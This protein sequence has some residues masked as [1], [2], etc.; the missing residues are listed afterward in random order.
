M[1]SWRSVLLSRVGVLL[2]RNERI[3][4]VFEASR[5]SEA[6]TEEPVIVVVASSSTWVFSDTTP[7]VALDRWRYSP[8]A[9]PFP[10]PVDGTFDAHGHRFIV[11]AGAMDGIQNAL[12]VR[13]PVALDDATGWR[14]D[15]S[16]TEWVR[17]LQWNRFTTVSRERPLQQT[18][19]ELLAERD[20]VMHDLVLANPAEVLPLSVS[21]TLG[22]ELTE[23]V[24]GGCRLLPG[25]RAWAAT[26]RPRRWPAPG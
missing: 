1:V 3:F 17:R 23:L 4:A 7:C 14:D 12:Y 9:K 24:A 19:F 25:A 11:E 18:R 5:A 26:Y 20:K 6:S 13:S 10:D 8:G 22:P 15:G 2:P 21:E 16:P